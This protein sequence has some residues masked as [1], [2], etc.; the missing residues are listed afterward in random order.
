MKKPYIVIL[1]SIILLFCSHAQF[2]YA[3]KT[4]KTINVNERWSKP[5]KQL[6]RDDYRDLYEAPANTLINSLVISYDVRSYESYGNTFRIECGRT[7]VRVR[8]DSSGE[9]TRETYDV[10]G[11]VVYLSAPGGVRGEATLHSVT[12][13]EYSID[14]VKAEVTDK[15]YVVFTIT[16]N[17]PNIKLEYKIE[18]ITTGKTIEEKSLVNTFSIKDL[19]PQL[20]LVNIYRLDWSNGRERTTY[21]YFEVY[22]PIDPQLRKSVHNEHG[23]TIDSVRD[24]DG[25]VLEEARNAKNIAKHIS[26]TQITNLENK[27]DNIETTINNIS[28]ADNMAPLVKVKTLS[29]ARATSANSIEALVNVTD[30]K[31]DSYEYSVNNGNYR[32]LPGDNTISLSPIHPGDN[33]FKIKVRDTQGNTGMDSIN[34]RGI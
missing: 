30:N 17:A 27:I 25:T 10:N 7:I 9:E 3:S 22:V 34:I 31:A 15:G 8:P 14:D 33:V 4:T 18:N 13:N 19:S 20:G 12:V 2:G 11:N 16:Q 23:S 6:S 28:G 21:G 5:L 24:K 29:G 26:E 32:N 1:L